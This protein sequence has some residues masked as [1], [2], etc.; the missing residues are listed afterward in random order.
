VRGLRLCY[1]ERGLQSI[2]AKCSRSEFSNF[3]KE[4]GKG[5]GEV[6]EINGN[7]EEKE[8][9][10]RPYLPWP[11]HVVQDRGVFGRREKKNLEA[12]VGEGKKE[13]LGEVCLILPR[14]LKVESQR[15]ALREEGGQK[16]TACAV[17][18]EEGK[19]ETRPTHRFEGFR[20]KEGRSASSSEER[21]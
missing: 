6:T 11:G 12:A 15:A 20:A 19:K 17:T 4:A 21:V 8:N 3:Q 16:G 13:R 10:G 14:Q 1:P 5:G 9:R 18:A 2:Q 7:L